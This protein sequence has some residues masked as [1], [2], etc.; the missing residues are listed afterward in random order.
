MLL[1]PFKE[2]FNL[3]TL[4]VEFGDS[5]RIKLGVVGNEPVNDT[6]SIVLICYHSDGFGVMFF[7]LVTCKSDQFITDNTRLVIN[8]IGTFNNILHVVFCPGDKKRSLLVDEIEHPKEIQVAKINHINSG[9]LN[10]KFIEDFDI[11]HGS[12]GQIDKNRKIA[13][14]VQQCMHLNTALVFPESSPWAELQTQAYSGAVKS[15]DQVVNVK[16]EVIIPLIHRACNINKHPGKICI[17]API[18]KLIGLC[19]GVS[20]NRMLNA[21]VIEFARDC[22]QAVFNIPK[23]VSLGK[24][25]KAHDIEMIPASKVADSMIPIVAVNTFI[26]FVFGYHGHKLSKDGLPLIHGDNRYD[27]ALNVD[28]KSFKDS[29]LV[30]YL[31]LTYYIITART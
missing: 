28:F 12:L 21:A 10:I 6:G 23:T 26:E 11:M 3:P 17:Y 14:E 18:T 25:G 13:S 2:K 31:L 9:W 1:D 27:I 19:K 20:R 4:P 8:T 29:T 16:P 5:E 7:R 30:M 24:L 15:I 22:F